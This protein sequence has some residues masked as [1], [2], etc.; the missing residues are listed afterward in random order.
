MTVSACDRVCKCAILRTCCALLIGRQLE[1]PP[2]PSKRS[3]SYVP[4]SVLIGWLIGVRLCGGSLLRAATPGAV[5]QCGPAVH[6]LTWV[7]LCGSSL[8]QGGCCRCGGGVQCGSVQPGCAVAGAAD[9]S[10]AAAAGAVAEYSAGVR[11]LDAP[12]QGTLMTAALSA[13]KALPDDAQAE[14]YARTLLHTAV[15]QLASLASATSHM[16]SANKLIM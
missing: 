6:N 5:A 3:T 14:G 15:A 12:L 13:A 10:R 16:S 4:V 8:L 11:N 9:C 7:R 2:Q 1:F